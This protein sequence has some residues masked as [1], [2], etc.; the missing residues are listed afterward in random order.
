MA[1]SNPKG[2]RE[3]TSSDLT[4]CAE[5]VGRSTARTTDGGVH[6]DTDHAGD[7]APGSLAEPN[8]PSGTSDRASTEPSVL[9]IDDNESVSPLGISR[10]WDLQLSAVESDAVHV[11][12]S[13]PASKLA[14]LAVSFG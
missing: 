12:R 6:H 2:L 8:L 11:S 9:P 5:S 13:L 14:E 10:A 7:G 3:T 4:N 1:S